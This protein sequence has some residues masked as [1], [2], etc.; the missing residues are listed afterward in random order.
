MTNTPKRK[1]SYQAG[2]CNIGDFEVK[3][4]MRS[5]WLGLALSLALYIVLTINHV[6]RWSYA[7]EFFPLMIFSS[8]LIQAQS[9]FCFAYGLKGL[10]NLGGK[11]DRFTVSEQEALKADRSYALTVLSRS[12]GVALI[13]TGLI[14]GIS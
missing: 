11:S 10:A 4:R 7:W 14:I 9:K 8:G 3:R 13:V 12:V 2:S 1:D 6:G 5:A